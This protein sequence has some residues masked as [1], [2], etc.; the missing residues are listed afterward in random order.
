MPADTMTMKMS[1]NCWCTSTS[2]GGAKA[3]QGEVQRQNSENVVLPALGEAEQ[4]GQPRGRCSLSASRNCWCTSTSCVCVCVLRLCAWWWG[5]GGERS[6]RSTRPLLATSDH[7]RIT[8]AQRLPQ[9]AACCGVSA[10]RHAGSASCYRQAGRQVPPAAAPR[11]PR[12]TCAPESVCQ[13]ISASWRLLNMPSGT[14]QRDTNARTGANSSRAACG[15]V[16]SASVSNDLWH[17]VAVRQT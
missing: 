10:V 13:M 8:T 9:P 11:W 2:W 5:G 4:H 1:R 12:P 6:G 14:F 17:S 15:G 7:C 3:A 16:A